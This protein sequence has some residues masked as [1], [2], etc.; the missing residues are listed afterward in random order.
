[1][2]FNPSIE[3]LK[4]IDFLKIDFFGYCVVKKKKRLGVHV[5]TY[6]IEIMHDWNEF[7][8]SEF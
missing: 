6:Y 2:K 1:M 5:Q 7:R 8:E 3:I 4:K